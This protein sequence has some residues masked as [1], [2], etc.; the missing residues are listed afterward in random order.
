MCIA[1]AGG[2]GV[3]CAGLT[4]AH[5]ICPF[6]RLRSPLSDP[7]P[8][9]A[10]DA[11]SSADA[12]PSPADPGPPAPA[13]GRL[14]PSPLARAAPA[15][16]RPA[17]APAAKGFALATFDLGTTTVQSS[18]A[19][20]GWNG[21]CCWGGSDGGGGG[22]GLRV[23]AGEKPNGEAGGDDATVSGVAVGR[24]HERLRSGAAAA[25]G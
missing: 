4:Q 21:C 7:D 16:A 18:T 24:P 10:A 17:R 22:D 3:A 23:L 15:P 11:A 25:K 13:L 1:K 6:D 12:S 19:G 5:R 20:A 2:E 9:A 8:S 14:W